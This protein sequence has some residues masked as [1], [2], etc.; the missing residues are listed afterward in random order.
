MQ[1]D[2][3]ISCGCKD[4]KLYPYSLLQGAANGVSSL[5]FY[6]SVEGATLLVGMDG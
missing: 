2:Q 6:H 4:S 1:I 3:R 5:G